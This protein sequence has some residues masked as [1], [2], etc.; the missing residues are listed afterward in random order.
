MTI[1]ATVSDTNKEAEWAQT[2]ITF[3][4]KTNGQTFEVSEWLNLGGELEEVDS[5]IETNQAGV[6]CAIL[7][8]NKTP[9]DRADFDQA[10]NEAVLLSRIFGRIDGAGNV[11]G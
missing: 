4:I 8:A 10:I 1:T 3:E 9:D 7:N 5:H 11:L 2:L 6:L